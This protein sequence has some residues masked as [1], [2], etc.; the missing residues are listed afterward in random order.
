MPARWKG[1]L[2]LSECFDFVPDYIDSSMRGVLVTTKKY[3]CSQTQTFRR[4]R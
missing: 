4:K 1:D 2:L 3:R